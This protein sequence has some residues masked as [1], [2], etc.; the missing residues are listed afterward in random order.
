[1][2]NDDLLCLAKVIHSYFSFFSEREIIVKMY[3]DNI[4]FN[5]ELTT[6]IENI[7]N[8]AIQVARYLEGDSECIKHKWV[9]SDNEVSTGGI[10]CLKCN[11]I[12]ANEGELEGESKRDCII[13]NLKK[14]YSDLLKSSGKIGIE[15][16]LLKSESGIAQDLDICMSQNSNLI[17]ENKTLSVENSE[18]SKS[19]VAITFQHKKI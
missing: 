1:M 18:M 5:S 12:K 10:I 11:A 7:I 17:A 3:G 4:E 9:S 14:S 16:K 8:I 13:K 19:L 6:S 2:K 15:N